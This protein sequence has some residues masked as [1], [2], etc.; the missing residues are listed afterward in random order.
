MT[1]SNRLR[2]IS[3]LIRRFPKLLLIPYYLYRFFQTKYTLG[4]VGIMLDEFG[5]V[6]LVEHVFHPDIP[7]GLPGGWMGY[8]E[9]P[10]HAVE[11]EIEEE[12]GL[13]VHVIRPVRIEKTNHNHID[14]AYLCEIQG[15]SKIGELSYELL[16]FRWCN[17]SELPTLRQFHARAITDALQSLENGVI[18]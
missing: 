11:R 3:H 13:V 4:V 5:N 6:L 10:A 12:L 8:N 1:K 17:P 18:S 15:D 7:W 9:D 16:E 2:H 14:F